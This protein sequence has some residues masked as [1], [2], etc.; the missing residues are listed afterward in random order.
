MGKPYALNRDPLVF[1]TIAAFAVLTT[2]LSAVLGQPFF[3][4]LQQ[5]IALTVFLALS[6]R[7]HDLRSALVVVF[8]WLGIS[9]LTLLI[10]TMLAP[11]MVERAFEDGFAHRA[12]YSEWYYAR[13]PLPASFTTQPL[14]SVVEIVGIT[15]GSLLTGGLVGVW[16]LVK[17]ANLAAFSAGALLLTLRNPLLLPIALPPWSIVQLVGAGGLVVVLAEP[18]LSGQFQAGIRQLTRS[19][20]KP[21]AI[22]GGLYGLGLLLELILPGIWHF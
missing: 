10:L 8:L 3:M 9:M 11:D 19:R 6:L 18:L 22:F 15:L 2:G 14:A 1:V 12:A 20:R 17:A 13:S 21:L 16:F 4:P 5:T 7:K